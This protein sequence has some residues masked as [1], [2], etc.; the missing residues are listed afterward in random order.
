VSNPL[1]V[2]HV[3]AFI[4]LTLAIVCVWLQRLLPWPQARFVWAAF[5]TTSLT[6]ALA[7]SLVD[8]RGVVALLVLAALCIGARR[9][10]NLAL[11]ALAQ[12][13]VLALS[14]ALFLHVIPGFFNPRI[15]SDA[16]LAP[17]SAP[18]TKYLNFDKGVAALCLVALYVPERA[19]RDEGARR[20]GAF[21]W[22]FALLVLVVMLASLAVGYVRWDPKLPSWWAMWLWSMVFFTAMPEETIFRGVAHSAIERWMGTSRN[23]AW[24]ATLVAGVLFGIAHGAGGPSYIVLASLAGI[25]YG[26]IYVSTRSL[27]LAIAAHAGLNTVHL[28]FFSYPALRIVGGP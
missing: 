26:W 17:D 8:L 15:V 27:S 2:A 5:A 7:S 20:L 28:L 16:M 4:A 13:A 23:A 21:A 22:R 14:A 10:N 9:T 18:Y 1:P 3:L 12:V 24:L 19:Q 25:G 6:I 11:A